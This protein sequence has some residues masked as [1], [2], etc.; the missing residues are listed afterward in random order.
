MV[1]ELLKDLKIYGNTGGGKASRLS[2]LVA[3]AELGLH[4]S[5]L[6]PADPLDHLTGCLQCSC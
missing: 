2:R 5:Y 4:L 1:V 6:S 3:E